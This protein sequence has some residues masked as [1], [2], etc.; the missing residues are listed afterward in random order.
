MKTLYIIVY[1][2]NTLRM[3]KNVSK[4]TVMINY[5][6]V[7]TSLKKFWIS[8]IRKLHKKIIYVSELP[9]GNRFGGL[10]FTNRE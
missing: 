10:S 1:T 3:S 2:N 5:L 7:M 8:I 9:S 6:L 4:R